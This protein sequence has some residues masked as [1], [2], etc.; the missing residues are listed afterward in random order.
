[1]SWRLNIGMTKRTPFLIVVG[2]LAI[3]LAIVC[4]CKDVGSA[5]L[6]YSY[7]GDA[8]TGIQNAAA[9]TANNILHL[10]EIAR[11]GF[12]SVLLVLGLGMI[13]E[14]SRISV[15]NADRAIIP[16]EQE[17]VKQELPDL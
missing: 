14:G 12:S 17:K 11:F 5:S 1:M 3:I 4:F 8:Y 6:G 2:I 13:V 15:G 10:A 16:E 9:Q 7:G